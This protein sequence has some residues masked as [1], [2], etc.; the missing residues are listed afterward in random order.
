MDR[1][2]LLIALLALLAV[3]GVALAASGFETP[4]PGSGGEGGGDTG[5]AVDPVEGPQ[6]VMEGFQDEFVV[7]ILYLAIVAAVLVGLV[8]GVLSGFVSNRSILF[9]ALAVLLVLGGL[10]AGFEGEP[11]DPFANS[12]NETRNFSYLDPAETNATAPNASEEGGGSVTPPTSMLVLFAGLLLLGVFVVGQFTRGRPE[13]PA[14]EPAVEDPTED[15]GRAAGRAA[16]RLADG[17]LSNVVYRAWRDMTDAL[18]VPD[19]ETTTPAEFGEAA[20]AAGFDEAD[21]RRLT[22]LFREV[23]Y[24][25][26]PVTAERERRARETLRRIEAAGGDET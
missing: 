14:T 15:V 17:E 13:E 20:V 12:T 26:E 1:N 24:G 8:A 4:E 11:R 22:D 9:G 5:P 3:V 6:P 23:R 21:V 18:D 25:D 16:D 7:R 2:R 19:P 10:L